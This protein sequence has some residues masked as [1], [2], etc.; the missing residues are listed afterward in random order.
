M[1]DVLLTKQVNFSADNYCNK[2]WGML[3][4]V[5][6]FRDCMGLI[7]TSK[8]TP[9]LLKQQTQGTPKRSTPEYPSGTLKGILTKTLT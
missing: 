1:A 4:P 6:S 8:L 2:V 5:L 7:K 9:S 3:S